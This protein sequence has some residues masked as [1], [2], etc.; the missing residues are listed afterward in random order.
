MRNAFAKEVTRIAKKSPKLVLLSG[1]IGNR[2][3]DEYKQIPKGNFLNCGIAEAKPCCPIS[4]HHQSL[5][6]ASG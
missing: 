1:D 6:L 3:F 2:L 5:V 4:A